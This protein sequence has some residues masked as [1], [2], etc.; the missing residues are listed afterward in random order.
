[1]SIRVAIVE[2]DPGM[3]R[4]LTEFISG[5]PGFSCVAAYGTAEEALKEAS[6]QDA[7]VV[8]VDIH[9]PLKSGID[10][11][12]E[13]APRNPQVHLIML[14][15]EED[16]KRVF[17][18]LKAGAT[19]YMLKHLAPEQILEAI[20]EVQRGGAPMSSQIARMVVSTFREPAPPSIHDE[21]SP[22]ENEILRCLACGDRSKEIA[23]KLGI[24]TA[25]VNT[26]IR[27]VYEKLHVRSRAQAVARMAR[28]QLPPLGGGEQPPE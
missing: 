20:R 23:D 25:T 27:N 28:R 8:L 9:L 24:A 11:V 7:Q 1:M 19:G 2:D 14:T 10:F 16:G 26:H 18:C 6:R 21:L 3:R 4:N 12:R 15:I 13:F 22:R 17:E 5:S